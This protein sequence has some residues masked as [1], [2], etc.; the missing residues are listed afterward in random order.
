MLT[1][2]RHVLNSLAIAR[3]A[4]A[5]PARVDRPLPTQRQVVPVP[6]A[7]SA[8]LPTRTSSIAMARPC[9]LPSITEKPPRGCVKSRPCKPCDACGC[10]NTIR[11]ATPHAEGRRPRDC[12][13]WLFLSSP[14]D[15][16]ARLGKKRTTQ[17]IGYKVH[18]TESCDDE[19]FHLLTMSKRRSP[20]AAIVTSCSRFTTLCKPKRSYRG[21]FADTGYGSEGGS[22]RW[23]GT[24][25]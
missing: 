25:A 7:E 24:L 10:N 14:N 9:S 15:P 17:W 11:L 20:L 5:T 2:P 4:R 19:D 23:R 22:C 18:L 16:D 8:G 12:P 3:V 1:E 6:A 21:H 13:A